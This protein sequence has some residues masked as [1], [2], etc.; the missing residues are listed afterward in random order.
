MVKDALAVVAG[1]PHHRIRV[2]GPDVGGGF[3]VKDH[4]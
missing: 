4:I 2:I 3:G 1:L